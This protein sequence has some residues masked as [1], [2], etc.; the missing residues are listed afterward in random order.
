MSGVR[1]FDEDGNPYE[2]KY[3]EVAARLRKERRQAQQ[4]EQAQPKK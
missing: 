2:L 4:N 3:P 1:I